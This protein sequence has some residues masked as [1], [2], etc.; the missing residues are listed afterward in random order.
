MAIR[1][2]DLRHRVIAPETAGGGLTLF[3]GHARDVDPRGARDADA[4]IQP[5]V[6]S[7]LESVG[8][9]MTARRGGAET[10]EHDL[11]GTGGLVTVHR[12]E[13]QVRRA[14]GPDAAEAALDAGEH[15]DLVREHG[16]LV[17]LPVVVGVLEDDDPVAEVEVKALLAVGVRI[18]L[19]DPQTAAL[20]PAH[21]DGLTDVR[22][23]GEE[24]GLESLGEMELGQR[25]DRLEDR[26]ALGLVVVR[27]RERCGDGRSTEEEGKTTDGHGGMTSL[28]DRCSASTPDLLRSPGR[29]GR[30]RRSKRSAR[31]K[32]LQP[33]R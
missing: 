3:L 16:T 11:G 4:A 25:I 17:E 8:E 21:R 15:L 23:S 7:P 5:A 22:F 18:V 12:D 9:S 24:R 2:E 33:A 27:L 26:D 31:A 14:D 32:R 28:R 1:L 30:R 6:R 10:I 29:S 20:V 13:D 19:G